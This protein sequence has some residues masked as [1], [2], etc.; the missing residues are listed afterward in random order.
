MNK[1]RLKIK[2]DIGYYDI[3]LIASLTVNDGVF[4][5]LKGDK[6]TNSFP[7]FFR[8]TDFDTTVETFNLVLISS[9]Y[10]LGYFIN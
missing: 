8:A 4:S 6:P 3:I 10:S 7:L 1:E 2:L 9:R 5:F